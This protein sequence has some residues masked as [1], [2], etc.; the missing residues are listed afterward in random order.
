MRSGS[1]ARPPAAYF[2]KHG[3][4]VVTTQ[5]E[6]PPGLEWDDDRYLGDAYGTYGWGCNVVELEIDQ[7]DVGSQTDQGHRRRRDWQGDSSDHGD[8]PGGGRDGP[9]P[10][11]RAARGG[12][13][14]RR[15]DGQCDA[16]ELHH[17][18]AARYAA[19]RNRASSNGRT[20]TG[21]MA[22]KAWAR[23][24]SMVRRLRS[25][26]HCGTPAIDMRAIPVDA[27]TDDDGR[28]VVTARA[29]AR[30]PSA[31]DDCL[32]VNGTSRRSTCIR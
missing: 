21:R 29:A 18:D 11:L 16:D 6:R 22:Q 2:R 4:F 3:A 1:T 7:R 30:R 17:S 14:A 8:W 13:D 25:S 32:Q 28:P 10:W 12:R 26:T 5:Y 23:C 27:R 9:G 24:R 15:A 31:D 20:S 19:Y